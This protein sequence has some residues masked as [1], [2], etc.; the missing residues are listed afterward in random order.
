M[1]REFYFH[2]MSRLALLACTFGLGC[3]TP[4]PLLALSGSQ[5]TPSDAVVQCMLPVYETLCF[6]QPA[7]GIV[8]V[9]YPIAFEPDDRAGTFERH[10]VPATYACRDFATAPR[11]PDRRRIAGF[12]PAIVVES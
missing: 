5:G 9:V 1:R 10:G 11:C 7:G 6:P 2:R 4:P 12:V 3:A 8:T